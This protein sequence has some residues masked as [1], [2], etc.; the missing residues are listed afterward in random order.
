MEAVLILGPGEV[1]E[2]AKIQDL[3]AKM[4]I[5]AGISEDV[6]KTVVSSEK[7][8]S[9]VIA[10]GKPPEKGFATRF[11]SLLEDASIRW[12]KKIKDKPID[13]HK[14]EK[15]SSVGPGDVVM[16]RLPPTKGTDGITVCGEIVPG[17][18]GDD[19]PFASRLNGVEVSPDDP[20]ILIATI[21]GKPV[22]VNHGVNIEDV[23][24]CNGV[25]YSTGSIS[26]S[27]SVRVNGNVNPGMYIKAEGDVYIS[28]TVESA[29][30]ESDGD[31]IIKGG[32]IGVKELHG[33]ETDSTDWMSHVKAKGMVMCLYAEHS[34]IEAYK[35]INIMNFALSSSLRAVEKITVGKK[36]AKMGAI[37]GGEAI[38]SQGIICNASGS[39]AGIPTKI[40]IMFS[41]IYTER[42]NFVQSQLKEAEGKIDRILKMMEMMKNSKILRHKTSD[43]ADKKLEHLINDKELLNTQLASI[44]ALESSLLQGKITIYRE[45]NPGLHA[46]IGDYSVDI[47]NHS[48][49]KTINLKTEEDGRLNIDLTA[50]V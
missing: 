23:Y 33:E 44:L 9:Y 29:S 1:P 49:G 45:I 15:V 24:T 27:G 32:I 26:F 35:T 43:N 11:E 34:I 6:L 39:N 2:T 5:V 46:N 16:R 47:E 36:G 28:G 8:E 20:N 30:I 25:D 19:I 22:V 18:F 12:P 21:G 38:S 17:L 37:I 3:L 7:G 42:K 31:V 41:E 50:P 14:I 13:W 4:N 10:R 48:P 40:S